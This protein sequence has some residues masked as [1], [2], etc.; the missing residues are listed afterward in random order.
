VSETPALSVLI[1]TH[2]RSELL[3][4]CLGALAEQTLAAERFEVL[5]ADDGSSDGTAAMLT[6]LRTPFALRVLALPKG[7]KIAALNAA[8]EAARGDVCVFIDDDVVASPALLAE[9]L[10]AH[11]RDPLTL[12]IGRLTQAEPGDGD[13][14]AAAH[15]ERWNARYD[16]L[17]ET[18]VDWADCF[19][20]NFSAPLAKLRGIGGFDAGLSAVEDLEIGYRLSAAGCVV[21]YLPAAAA[22][23]D[24]EKPALRVLA[25]EERFGRFCAD[26]VAA[27]PETRRRLVGWFHKPT[28]RD[29][30]LRRLFLAL[31]ATPRALFAAGSLLP[32]RARPVWYGFVG[33]YAFWRGV[34]AAASRREW[35]RTTR[36]VPVLMYHAF[37]DSGER[38]RWVVPTR[39]FERQLRLL[40]ALRYRIVSLDELARA[41]RE[42]ADLPK[43]TAVITID[44]GYRDN[45]ELA[46]PI[47]R[48]YGFPA[49]VFLV[50]ER[51]G[52]VYDWDDVGVVAGRPLLDREQI[53]ELRAGGVL[54]GAHTRTHPPLDTLADE[55]L[56]LQ[57]GGSRRDLEATLGQEIPTLTYPYGRWD[58][59]TPRAAAAA[60]LLAACTTEARPARFGDDPHLIPRIE[61]S[62][63][64][65]TRNFLRK[66]WFAGH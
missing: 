48:R 14:F 22:V 25:D 10:A 40:R 39:E 12:G 41:L 26:F 33:R 63:F 19:G 11:E 5:I 30:A 13:L 52:G 35:R 24:D 7:G 20:G 62:G 54:L 64:D 65:R 51:I 43:R 28:P 53:E 23:H 9:H 29:V 34:R 37:T 15:A 58:E 47:L 59:R 46:L 6:E 60:D 56:A 1:A 21:R 18:A 17:E 38:D 16:E 2:N 8:I 42:G 55:E 27:H 45:L 3:R 49:T 4:R 44:D 50:S 36:G 31:H 66:L 57:V 32:R 61:I